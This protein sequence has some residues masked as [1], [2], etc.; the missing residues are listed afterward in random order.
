MKNNISQFP[1]PICRKLTYVIGSD[2]KGK[3]IGNCGCA[4]HFRQTKSQKEAER[5]W[6]KTP[7]G[8]ERIK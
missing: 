5:K 3:K 2:V 4:W 6:V 8:L 7:Y 1:C